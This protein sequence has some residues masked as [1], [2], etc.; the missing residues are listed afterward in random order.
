M[1]PLD[2]KELDQLLRRWQAPQA[3]ATLEQRVFP[4]A[5]SWWRWLLKGTIR[6][7]VPVGVAIV[8]V[9]ALWIYYST[10]A[11]TPSAAKPPEPV[12][13]VDFKPVQQLEPVI[14]VGGQT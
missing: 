8:F 13:L 4:T 9:T 12:S 1:E 14:V 6:I 10:P 5:R 7:P 11:A 2:D 3:P